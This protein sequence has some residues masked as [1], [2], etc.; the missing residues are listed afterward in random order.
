MNESKVEQIKQAYESDNVSV[1]R[2]VGV[3]IVGMTLLF[4]L[5]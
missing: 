1:A 3:I 2:L 4:S 5:I